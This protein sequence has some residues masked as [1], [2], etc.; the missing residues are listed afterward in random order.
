MQPTNIMAQM[1]EHSE[2]PCGGGEGVRSTD[3]GGT[4]TGEGQQLSPG[5]DG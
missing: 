2:E 3:A 4:H 5:T 1:R